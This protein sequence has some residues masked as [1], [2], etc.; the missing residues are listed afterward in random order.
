MKAKAGGEAGEV[1]RPESG[2]TARSLFVPV[3]GLRAVCPQLGI[4]GGPVA[5]NAIVTVH[6]YRWGHRGWGERVG[7]APT[8]PTSED[9][10][11]RCSPSGRSG[12]VPRPQSNRKLV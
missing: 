3:L 2:T 6:Y 8:P 7:L 5:A 1:G 12:R 10:R 9:S 4:L 11:T